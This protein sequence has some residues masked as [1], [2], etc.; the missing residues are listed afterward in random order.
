MQCHVDCRP[1]ARRQARHGAGQDTQAEEAS[2]AECRLL[3]PRGEAEE[4]GEW[5]REE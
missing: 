2:V 3:S 5:V 4:E 1:H